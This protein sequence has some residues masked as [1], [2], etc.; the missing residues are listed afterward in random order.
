[1][2]MSKIRK[3]HIFNIH[4][5]KLPYPIT[6]NH[7]ENPRGATLHIHAVNPCNSGPY[8]THCGWTRK[9]VAGSCLPH[10]NSCERVRPAGFFT[11]HVRGGGQRVFTGHVA[12]RKG[13]EGVPT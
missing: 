2:K 12:K 5:H 13:E 6:D 1:M 3:L 7:P 10:G 4:E 9:R 11:P 8:P